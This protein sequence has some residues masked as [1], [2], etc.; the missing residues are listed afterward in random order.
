MSD[1]YTPLL[2]GDGDTA[3]GGRTGF[4]FGG[5]DIKINYK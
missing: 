2:T 5:A 3:G 4:G 1:K